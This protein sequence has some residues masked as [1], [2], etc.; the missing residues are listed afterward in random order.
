MCSRRGLDPGSKCSVLTEQT[1]L[2]IIMKMLRPTA[3]EAR[4]I[5]DIAAAYEANGLPR[6]AGRIFAWLL[7]S[8]AEAHT[9]DELREAL[10][11]AKSSI[12]T[13]IRLLERLGLV[14]RTRAPGERSDR[15]RVRP[16]AVAEVLRAKLAGF[17]RFR[18]LAQE[19]LSLKRAG[20]PARRRLREIDEIYAFFE[21]EFPPLLDRLSKRSR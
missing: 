15:F 7:V 20:S 21:R 2:L 19:G 16:G 18:A 5:E 6:V 12:S 14:E 10:G 17:S 11:A 8:D 13:M 4:L 9:A 3:R 1:E